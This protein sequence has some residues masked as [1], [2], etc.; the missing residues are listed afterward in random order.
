MYVT[1]QCDRCQHNSVYRRSVYGRRSNVVVISKPRQARHKICLWWP[2]EQCGM[3]WRSDDM[4]MRAPPSECDN[5]RCST[6]TLDDDG[7]VLIIVVCTRRSLV[8][9]Y[10]IHC[11]PPGRL[12]AEYRP[13][14]ARSLAAGATIQSTA[15]AEVSDRS[16][17]SWRVLIM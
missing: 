7:V 17:R 13:V 8:A 9:I 1:M 14:D 5:D 3:E 16:R 4:A 6:W 15:V 2:S 11:Q 10:R 12:E